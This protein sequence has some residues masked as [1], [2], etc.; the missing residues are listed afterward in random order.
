MTTIQ[1]KH[2]E[3]LKELLGLEGDRQLEKRDE[4]GHTPLLAASINGFSAGASLLIKEG[5]NC[6]VQSTNSQ[7]TPLITASDKGNSKVVEILLQHQA[8]VDISNDIEQTP[9]HLASEKGNENIVKQLLKAKA[10]VDAEDKDGKTA[11]HLTSGAGPED[12]SE[13]EG[14][15]GPDEK[16]MAE[17]RSGRH[18]AVVKLLLKHGAKP[19]AKTNKNETALHLAVARGDPARLDL[20]LASMGQEHMS[21]KNDQGRTALDLAYTGDNTADARESL[22]KSDKLR[23]AEFG[24]SDVGDDDDKIKWAAKHRD[25]YFHEMA[26]KLMEERLAKREIAEPTG[27]HGWSVIQW[28]AYSQLPEVLSLLIEHSPKSSDTQA[29]LK[30]ALKSKLESTLQSVREHKEDAEQSKFCKTLKLLIADVLPTPDL[31]E[32]MKFVLD[33]TLDLVLGTGVNQG[34]GHKQLL[35]VLSLLTDS[36][37]GTPEIKN[38]LRSALRSAKKAEDQPQG[39]EQG[40][41]PPKIS[42]DEAGTSSQK[43]KEK[44]P[45]KTKNRRGKTAQPTAPA[46]ELETDYQR[47]LV[48]ILR[49]PPFSQTYKDIRIDGPPKHN[50]ELSETL[51]NLEATIVQFYKSEGESG[52]F[53]RYRSLKEVIYDNG[54]GTIMEK[55]ISDLKKVLGERSGVP[56]SLTYLE[57]EPKFTWVHLPATNVSGPRLVYALVSRR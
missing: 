2:E 20:I 46:K 41:I 28:T 13:Q 22:L 39:P 21:V 24:K 38:K 45:E 37:S 27:S 48:D 23:T 30:Y 36:F 6:N 57:T 42:K 8:D 26:Q 9:L 50:P 53:R 54:P 32:A 43:G 55:T 29:A 14:E 25:P 1:Q 3:I 11:L 51:K 15:L 44:G 47:A 12:Y 4:L 49:D 34:A 19:E 10:K 33:V 5:A 40:S 56:D 52:A 7:W 17:F 35:Q 18:A 31:G 16:E